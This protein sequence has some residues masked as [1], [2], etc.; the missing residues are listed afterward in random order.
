MAFATTARPGQETKFAAALNA[1]MEEMNLGIN[2]V[3]RMTSSTYEYIRKLSRGLALPSKYMINTLAG[4]LKLD[5]GE[6]L[7]MSVEDKLRLKHGD[8]YLRARGISPSTNLS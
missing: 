2:D 5:A 6:L 1:R 7:D 4:V 8:S 3:A